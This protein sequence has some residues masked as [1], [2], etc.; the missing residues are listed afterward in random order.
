M[1]G[2]L[3][4]ISNNNYLEI[5]T[6]ADLKV[7]RGKVP[8]LGKIRSFKRCQM[9]DGVIYHSTRYKRVTA[10]TN[11]TIYFFKKG[12]RYDFPFSIV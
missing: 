3:E 5:F 12:S 6:D 10:R 11:F 1:I 9:I 8:R 2:A 7:I 4:D